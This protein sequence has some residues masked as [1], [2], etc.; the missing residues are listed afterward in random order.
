[1]TFEPL[2]EN[3]VTGVKELAKWYAEGLIDPEI[4]TRGAKSRDILYSANQ[5]GFTHDWPST[6]NYNRSLAEEIPGFNNIAIAPL[7]NSNGEVIERT[8]R[9]AGVG[10]GGISSQV[11][12]PVTLIQFFD[13]MFTEEGSTYM[14]WGGIEGDTYTVNADGSKSYTDKV[15]NDA[16]NTPLAVLR[17]MGGIQYRIGMYQEAEY[18]YAFMTPEA[19]AAA[20]LYNGHPEWFRESMPPYADGKLNLKYTAEDEAEYKKIMSQVRP[21]VD[22]M[23]QKWMLGAANIDDDYASFVAELKA[24]NIERAIE[25]NQTAYKTFLGDN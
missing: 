2:T 18:E 11:E 8:T 1:M 21:Y 17:G 16:D 13:Y 22:E 4:F 7:K 24:R 12:D 3:F 9:Y 25:I 5:G 20:K 14:N 23:F 6:G 19:S 15:M 10:W